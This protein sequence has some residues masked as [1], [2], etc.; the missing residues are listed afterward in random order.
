[1]MIKYD[2]LK[3]ENSSCDEET[4]TNSSDVKPTEKEPLMGYIYGVHCG[5]KNC[6]SCG[7]QRYNCEN[8]NEADIEV[9]VEAECRN[10]SIETV[11]QDRG[12]N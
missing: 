3:Y 6:Y 12:V 10:V 2:K 7:T 9:E 5:D 1:M 8:L 11:L 4:R